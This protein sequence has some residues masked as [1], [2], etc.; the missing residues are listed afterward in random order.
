[1]DYGNPTNGQSGSPR[2]GLSGSPAPANV[3]VRPQ[4]PA[5]TMRPPQ[6]LTFLASKMPSP[7]LSPGLR[8]DIHNYSKAL[9]AAPSGTSPRDAL[10][11]SSDTAHLP[12]WAR[13][14]V[15]GAGGNPNDF[16]VH[17]GQLMSAMTPEQLHASV[18]TA[19]PSAQLAPPTSSSPPHPAPAAVPSIGVQGA[20]PV[21]GR[22]GISQGPVNATSAPMGQSQPS[23]LL[24]APASVPT[25][26]PLR[27]GGTWS[28]TPAPAS[29]SSASAPNPATHDPFQAAM[30]G[31]LK[32]AQDS[33]R[34]GNAQDWANHRAH[35]GNL[36]D[37]YQRYNLG[38]SQTAANDPGN[39]LGLLRAINADPSLR[40]TYLAGRGA[41]PATIAALPRPYAPGENPFN[42]TNYET[43]G[44]ANPETAGTAALLSGA[45]PLHEKVAAVASIPGVERPGNP[46][47][48]LLDAY[49]ASRQAKGA[50][51]A[52]EL[53]QYGVGSPTYAPLHSNWIGQLY[54]DLG[55]D[56]AVR[57]RNQSFHADMAKL[58][59]APAPLTQ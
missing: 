59:Y 43:A 12:E 48:N 53:S 31:N 32:D 41:D 36:A 34:G 7:A 47:R 10:A 19:K 56:A 37:A 55:G 22:P 24:P 16:V 45:S 17:G 18:L 42:A 52:N 54:G 9:L 29:S 49:M 33:F 26:M 4:L 20:A 58:G 57:S 25:I 35:I 23:S 44:A 38:A 5:P 1:M 40:A 6:P 21:Q 51:F 13:S 8:Q 3:G 2:I 15:A 30:L 46:H 27:S 50:D 14:H 11:A 39:Q 28:T